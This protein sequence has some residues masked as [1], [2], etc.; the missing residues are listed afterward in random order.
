MRL[1]IA[2]NELYADNIKVGLGLLRSLY[3]EQNALGNRMIDIYYAN[4][5]VLSRE[6][7]AAIPILRTAIHND[8][9]EPYYHILLSRAYGELGDQYRSY[10]ERGEYHYLRGNY[11]FSLTQFRRAKELTESEYELERIRARIKD[12]EEALEA[13][14]KYR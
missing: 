14:K 4:A 11:S 9:T 7:E 12:I 2:E 5:L 13:L 10:Y 1:S 6:H 8:K 3:K